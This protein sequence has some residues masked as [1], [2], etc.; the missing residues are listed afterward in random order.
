MRG[1]P[2]G[3]P[4]TFF[5]YVHFL[6][7]ISFKLRYDYL[8]MKVTN[9][10]LGRNTM[11]RITHADVAEN[12][13]TW[14]RHAMIVTGNNEHAFRDS[15][16]AAHHGRLHLEETTELTPPPAR[17]ITTAGDLHKGDRVRLRHD[18][19]RFPH[20]LV[21]AGEL[22]TVVDVEVS[23]NTGTVHCVAV[24]LLTHFDGLDDWSNE[25]H[26]YSD[27]SSVDD[28]PEGLEVVS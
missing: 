19:H 26:W 11:T 20:A 13:G 16:M 21:P 28:I 22:G 14:A 15:R 12:F 5:T 7:D 10:N 1:G 3:L 8:T 25:L 4:Q 2:S 9:N 23:A 6:V 17:R 18:A 27:D 24:Q